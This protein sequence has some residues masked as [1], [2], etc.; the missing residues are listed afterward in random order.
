VK[1][2][3]AGLLLALTATG[4]SEAKDRAQDLAKDTA[5]DAAC[6]VAQRTMDQVVAQTQGAVDE[7]GVDPAAAE[8]KLVALRD[9]LKAA[10]SGL[11]GE[12]RARIAEARTAL[13]GLV[14]E[15]E[16][17]AAGAPVDEEQVQR[18]RDDLDGAVTG[19]TRL[20]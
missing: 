6:S 12:T 7:L 10:E 20:C 14:A 2:I 11:G 16:R 3:A 9:T 19:L 15:A 1:I 18:A 17:E 13:D 8:Q 4:C 5:S